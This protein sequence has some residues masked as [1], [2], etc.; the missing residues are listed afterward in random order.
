MGGKKVRSLE[1][2]KQLKSVREGK[3]SASSTPSGGMGSVGPNDPLVGMEVDVRELKM[4]VVDQIASGYNSCPS[5]AL[6]VGV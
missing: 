2:K 6:L 3:G 4:N 5:A 1:K